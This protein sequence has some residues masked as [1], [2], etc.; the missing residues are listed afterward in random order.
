MVILVSWPTTISTATATA[1]TAAT[2]TTVTT[3]TTTAA[4][5]HPGRE[6][7]EGSHYGRGHRVAGPPEGPL[8]FCRA[9][10]H[11]QRG[12]WWHNHCRAEDE[13]VSRG[14]RIQG[15]TVATDQSDCIRPRCTVVV[16]VDEPAE[17]VLQARGR[18][19]TDR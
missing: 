3:A 13:W 10:Q 2:A 19:P 7:G 12:G 4:T 6:R 5:T 9:K 8:R 16:T 15:H 14:G 11:G 1:T 18:H 17:A